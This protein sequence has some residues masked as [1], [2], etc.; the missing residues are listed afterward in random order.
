M[1]IGLIA[2]STNTG[3]GYQTL[4]FAKHI[5]CRKILIS[6][7]SKFNGM[8]TH[9]DRFDGLAQVKIADGLPTDDDCE[10]LTDGVDLLFVCETPLNWKLFDIARAKGVKTV[11]QYNWEFLPYPLDPS[12]PKPDLLASPSY[13]MIEEAKAIG[14]PV[15]YLPVPIDTDKIPFRRFPIA[16]LSTFVHIVGRPAVHDRNGTLAFLKAAMNLPQFNYKVFIQTPKEPGAVENYTIIKTELD[17]V[18]DVIRGLGGTLEVI[19]DVENN[20][21]MYAE[22]ECLVLPRKF[23]G[24]CLP[25][26][27]ALSA[28]MPV[29]MTNISPND[30]VLPSDWLCNAHP[31]GATKLRSGVP[32]YEA[33]VASL[34][35]RMSEI[36]EAPRL[37]KANAQAN[38]LADGMSWRVQRENYQRTFELLCDL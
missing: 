2:F 33:D 12:L 3:L 30:K 10:W 26:W 22:G 19:E 23:G 9:H 8:P 21:D 28:G 1:R 37:V 32:M 6:D 4:E 11:L 7:L 36:S 14:V 31:A 15:S 35:T 27:E 17:V 20:V 5:A 34:T 18:S 13:W 16:N 29:I 38:L 24:L 25:L